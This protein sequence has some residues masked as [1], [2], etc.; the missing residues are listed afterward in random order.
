MNYAQRLRDARED[1]D[2]KQS[3]VAIILKTT[4]SYY[5]QYENGHRKLPIEHLITLCKYY[6]LSADYMLGFI[7]DP[8]PLK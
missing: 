8:K 4:Q 2:L 6:N 7:N 5:A 1:K 3:D